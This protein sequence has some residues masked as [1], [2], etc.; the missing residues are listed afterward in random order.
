MKHMNEIMISF[1]RVQIT[2]EA[3]E[4]KDHADCLQRSVS[5]LCLAGRRV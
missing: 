1:E 4:E 5:H 2:S 3:T